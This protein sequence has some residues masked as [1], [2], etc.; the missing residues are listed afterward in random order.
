MKYHDYT[1]NLL[2]GGAN[3]KT[4]TKKLKTGSTIIV[5]TPGRLLDHMQNTPNF[6]YQK[7]QCL[8]IDEAD[9][10]LDIGAGEDMKQIL[11]KLP[12]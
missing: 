11:K 5:A 9:I 12:S 7:L 6:M 4:E 8:I 3:K 10:I 2:I 1:Y